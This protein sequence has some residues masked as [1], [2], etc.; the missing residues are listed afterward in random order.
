MC[1][2]S[3][4]FNR[5]GN[6][7]SALIPSVIRWHL[8][9]VFFENWLS[10]YVWFGIRH[11]IFKWPGNIGAISCSA[12]LNQV[13]LFAISTARWS[14]WSAVCISG[15]VNV[16]TGC[17]GLGQW[18]GQIPCITGIVPCSQRS[19]YLFW[20]PFH[21]TD[22]VNIQLASAFFS[23]PTSAIS[24]VNI[25]QLAAVPWSR[26]YRWYLSR[27]MVTVRDTIGHICWIH[28]MILLLGRKWTAH[29][30]LEILESRTKRGKVD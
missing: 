9:S 30:G 15:L 16:N 20:D 14:D 2:A 17:C 23:G 28:T 3:T 26:I 10:E 11:I 4:F 5:L 18:N 6:S 27:R 12:R 1:R 24:P 29:T 21:P 7:S 25:Q 13:M 22:A 8:L 19:T